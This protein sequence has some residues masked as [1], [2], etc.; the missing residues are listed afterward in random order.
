MEI[1]SV[2]WVGVYTANYEAMVRMLGDVMG[3]R[4]NFERP[5]P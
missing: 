2:R 1:R 4:V 3:L 5:P